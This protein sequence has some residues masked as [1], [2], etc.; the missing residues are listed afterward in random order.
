MLPLQHLGEAGGVGWR[1]RESAHAYATLV[2][3]AG[4]SCLGIS[5]GPRTIDG[6]P[7]TSP[8]PWDSGPGEK[9]P[10]LQPQPPIVRVPTISPHPPYPYNP[11]TPYPYASAFKR[12]IRIAIRDSRMRSE[13]AASRMRK[14]VGQAE[15]AS[16]H[17]SCIPPVANHLQLN[18]VTSSRNIIARTPTI[19]A[20][21]LLSTLRI[22]FRTCPV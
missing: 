18:R 10:A 17:A 21:I 12:A 1:D 4:E 7:V 8:R 15:L 13:L 20:T 11:R 6:A 22:P 16:W 14:R 19:R 5:C 9:A 2:G 3:G